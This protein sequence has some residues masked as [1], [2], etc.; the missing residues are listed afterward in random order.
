M[1]DHTRVK[2]RYASYM[3]LA[4]AIVYGNASLAAPPAP[5]GIFDSVFWFRALLSGMLA[6]LIYIARNSEKRLQQAESKLTSLDRIAIERGSTLTQYH[7]RLLFLE[8][9]TKAQGQSL[10]LLERLVLTKYDDKA[11]T[12]KHRVRVEDQLR[13]IRAQLDRMG[14]MGHRRSDDTDPAHE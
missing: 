3:G 7:G 13:D 4:F 9:E 12:E 10:V 6:V 8:N 2:L 14:R 11:E 5:D 1:R